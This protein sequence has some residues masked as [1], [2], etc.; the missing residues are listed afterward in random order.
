MLS[1]LLNSDIAIRVNIDYN[2]TN[3]DSRMQF[4]LILDFFSYLLHN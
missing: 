4:E 2:D 3:E 1:G